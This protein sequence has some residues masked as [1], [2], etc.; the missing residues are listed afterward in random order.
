MRTHGD[1]CAS[2]SRT[3]CTSCETMAKHVEDVAH[4]SALTSFDA[5]EMHGSI[6]HSS[7]CTA[8]HGRIACC[9]LAHDHMPNH[10]QNICMHG[11]MLQCPEPTIAGS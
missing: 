7:A 6:A 5:M 11:D 10:T 8:T 2:A 9:D 3:S 1:A 4:R